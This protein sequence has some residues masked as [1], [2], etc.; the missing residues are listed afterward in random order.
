M[1]ARTK[2]LAALKKKYKHWGKPEE[3]KIKQDFDTLVTAELER[4]KNVAVPK[5]L[6]DDFQSAAHSLL[7]SRMK[8]DR[9]TDN[10]WIRI[11]VP[12]TLFYSFVYP[13]L[14]N[15]WHWSAHHGDWS[16]ANYRHR[17]CASLEK[18]KHVR[19]LF[20]DLFVAP[21]QQ[22]ELSGYNADPNSGEVSGFIS[23]LDYT[24]VFKFSV[25]VLP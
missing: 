21:L 2:E 24:K 11:A 15:V 22:P 12:R 25:I 4:A 16:Q 3:S 17:V 14:K 1:K 5:H 6:I 18:I 7:C 13:H 23:F 19:C 20:G 9:C 8:Y 10:A